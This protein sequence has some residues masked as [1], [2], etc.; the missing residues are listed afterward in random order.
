M[1]QPLEVPVLPMPLLRPVPIST[2]GLGFFARLWVLITAVR[3]WEVAENYFFVMP[4]GQLV[5]IPKGFIFDGASTPKFLWGLL[6]PTGVLLIQGLIH[7]FGYRYDYLW[8]FNEKRQLYKLHLGGCREF[9][10]QLFLDIG[11][12]LYDL[13]V[14]GYLSWLMLRIF[15]WLAWKKNRELNDPDII[16]SY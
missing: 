5:M 9:W 13:Q 15:G 7:D 14:T 2:K 3:K 12:D 16:I 6:D 10:D 8:A 11:N 1:T 4:D